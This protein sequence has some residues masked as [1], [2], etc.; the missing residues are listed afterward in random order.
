MDVAAPRKHG[1]ADRRALH[2]EKFQIT[3][4]KEDE[5]EF[6]NNIRDLKNL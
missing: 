4:N 1:A 2:P 6:H 3:N 5:E